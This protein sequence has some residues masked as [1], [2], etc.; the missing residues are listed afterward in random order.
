[1]E[2]ELINQKQLVIEEDEIDLIDLLKT[3]YKNRIL[4]IGITVVVTILGLIFALRQT[5]TYKSEVTF[6]E[7]TTSSSNSML[8]SLAS[9]IPF[10]LGG[11]I[12]GGE[13]SS[14][15]TVLDSRSF[16]ERVA[17]KLKLR[18]YIIEITGM[19]KEAQ[20]KFD[21]I[22]VANWLKGAAIVAQD[23]KTGVYTISVE[24][25]D[26]ELATKIAN[27]YF[28]V[29]D[30]YIKNTKIDKNKINREYLEK[31][32][33][34][35]EKDLE[36]KQ[37]IVKAF[38][39]KYNSA[40]IE[41]DSKIAMESVAIIK[42]EILKTESELNVA[43][44]IYGEESLDVKRLKDMLFEYNKQLNNLNK[45]TGSVKFVPVNDITNIKYDLEKLKTEI[46]ATAEVYKMLRVQL[47]QAKL[48]EISNRSTIELLDEAV[49]P[50]F[51]S[52]TSRKLILLISGVLGLF[53]GVFV[54]F[55]KEFAKGINWQEFKN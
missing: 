21:M 31:Q 48:D 30:D 14:L 29:L 38:E 52:S 25:E 51:S 23:A 18:E 12:S 42:G 49:I 50:K 36:I 32:V 1:M 8:A 26:K 16:R 54:A 15:T 24:L 47:E 3:I 5:K 4:I 27:E 10:G 9:S 11:N 43:R 46:T 41:A 40:S 7:Q 39:K 53:T 33:Q 35:V 17:K 28:N 55:V 20:K 2:K 45:G 22:E 19:E 13:S 44:G 37:G 34:S 6:I